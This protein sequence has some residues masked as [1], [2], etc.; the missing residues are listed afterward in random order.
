MYI[1]TKSKGSFFNYVVNRPKSQQRK[2]GCS[3][4]VRTDTLSC[5]LWDIYIS[6][7][8]DK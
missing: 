2:S 8:D 6:K 7:I 3:Y 4:L 1:H 5:I